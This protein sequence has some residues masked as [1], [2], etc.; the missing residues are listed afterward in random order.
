MGNDE[1]K[2]PDAT[3][4][5]QPVKQVSKIVITRLNLGFECNQCPENGV[6]NERDVDDQDQYPKRQRAIIKGVDFL[7]IDFCT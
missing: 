7:I 5:L 2:H 4:T 3:E 1:E 6:K